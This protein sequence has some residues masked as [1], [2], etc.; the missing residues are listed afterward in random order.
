[1]IGIT[2]VIVVTIVVMYN[3]HKNYVKDKNRI[4]QLEQRL[5]EYYNKRENRLLKKFRDIEQQ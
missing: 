2:I 3:Q 1:M 5:E 4:N